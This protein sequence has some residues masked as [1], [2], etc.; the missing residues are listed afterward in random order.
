MFRIRRVFDDLLPFD[1]REI[2][3]VQALL[4]EQFP[5]IDATE[6]DALPEKLRNP[7]KQQFRSFLYVA[8]DTQAR[9]SGFAL[10][11]LEPRIGVWFLD[12]IAASLRGTGG[13]GG[14]LYA[15]LR[16]EAAS[17]P[18]TRGLFFEC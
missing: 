6:V 2:A 9:I 4:K 17:N 10:V 13:V 15:R 12:Y 7:F 16:E 5:G 1:A 3:Q 8:D 14:A 18:P 11:S